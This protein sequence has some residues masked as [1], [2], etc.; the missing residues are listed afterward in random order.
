MNDKTLISI[1]SVLNKNITFLSLTG[2]DI[3]SNSL[4]NLSKFINL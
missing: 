4:D 3:T 1:L 2:T